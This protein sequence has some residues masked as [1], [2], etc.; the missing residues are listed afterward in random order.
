[1]ARGIINWKTDC[2]LEPL[3][4]QVQ[5]VVLCR[6]LFWEGQTSVCNSVAVNSSP[7]F[8]PVAGS[9]ASVPNPINCWLPSCPLEPK[10]CSAV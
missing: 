9:L 4:G 6:M 1:M 10:T 8:S 3:F 5:R 2:I 7:D